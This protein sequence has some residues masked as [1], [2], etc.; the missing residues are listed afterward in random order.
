[1][2]SFISPVELKKWSMFSLTSVW[3]S[4]HGQQGSR[5]AR[6]KG[7]SQEYSGFRYYSPGDDVRQ[8]DWNAYGRTNRYVIKEFYDHVEQHVC[9]FTD[10]T[11]SMKVT[12]DKWRQL[13]RMMSALAVMT[14][15]NQ[16]R[17]RLV[18]VPVLAQTPE[19]QRRG[20]L[21]FYLKKI[22]NL[23]EPDGTSF[24]DGLS[25]WLGRFSLP[26]GLSIILSDFLEEAK[27]LER[28]LS[29][30]SSCHQKVICLQILDA[31]EMDPPFS[32]DLRLIDVE[33]SGVREVSF[34]KKVREHYESTFN[35]HQQKLKET[36]KKFGAAFVTIRADDTIDD[37]IYK[38]LMPQGLITMG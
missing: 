32:G 28:L 31:Y 17:L 12:Y 3:A 26:R 33:D 20:N 2:S 16:D 14:T 8:I 29:R 1:M 36:A 23:T 4:Q 13:Q 5:R 22:R 24:M 38:Q 34:S 7:H 19:L 27:G 11:S 10:M 30:L 21:H 6:K 37:I 15:A 9:L 25:E 18:P 35:G